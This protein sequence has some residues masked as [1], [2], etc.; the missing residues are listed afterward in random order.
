M[1]TGLQCEPATIRN[2]RRAASSKAR[3]RRTVAEQGEHALLVAVPALAAKRCIACLRRQLRLRNGRSARC[4]VLR[5]SHRKQLNVLAVGAALRQQRRHVTLL[6][7]C[8]E[9]LVFA[10]F[11]R[12]R[13]REW[14]CGAVCFLR[15]GGRARRH[16]LR[17]APRQQPRDGAESGAGGAGQQIGQ[18]AQ[19]RIRARARRCACEQAARRARPRQQPPERRPHHRAHACRAAASARSAA[20]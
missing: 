2:T 14:R 13:R 11:Q 7:V 3:Q 8:A 4:V 18:V 12:Q 5:I 20:R 6:R 17:H 9:R 19:R 15:P 1:R 10:A 16:R